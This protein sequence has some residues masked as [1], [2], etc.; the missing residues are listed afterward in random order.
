MVRLESKKN[1]AKKKHG[2]RDIDELRERAAKAEEH[3]RKA[4]ENIETVKRTGEEEEA[5]FN[6]R[7]EWGVRALG[8]G[9][10]SPTHKICLQPTPMRPTLPRP[11]PPRSGQ[12]HPTQPILT[13]LDL[14]ACPHT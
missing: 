11:P 4:M 14:C 3:F 2:G 5:A 6:R 1:H 10:F 12:S 7:Y 8:M 13:R 9:G